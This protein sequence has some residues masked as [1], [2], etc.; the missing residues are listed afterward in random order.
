LWFNFAF[1]VAFASSVAIATT[2]SRRATRR[3]GGTLNQL[4]HEVRGLIVVR[5]ALGLVFYATL[6]AWL[7]W[8]RALA[9]TYVPAPPQV[10]AGR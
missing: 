4:S 1:L 9:W 10:S 8:S 2:T 6:I 3:H 7:F 5:A